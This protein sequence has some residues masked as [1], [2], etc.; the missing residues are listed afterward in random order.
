MSCGPEPLTLFSMK[1]VSVLLAAGKGT[2]MRSETP[3]VLHPLLGA[4]LLEHVLRASRSASS[5][6]AHDVQQ[7]VVVGH[8]AAEV[9]AAFADHE[10][11][12]NI[13]WAV[14]TEQLG[15]GHA[16]RIGVDRARA[17]DD[18]DSATRILILNGDLPL[19]S[20]ETLHG[21]L[22]DFEAVDADVALLTCEADDPTGYGRIQRDSTGRLTGIIEEQDADDQT[23][24][25]KEINVGTYLFRA[26]V[27]LECAGRIDASNAQGEFYLTDV[28]VD[29]AR[30]GQKVVTRGVANLDEIAQVNNRVDLARVGTLLRAQLLEAYMESGVT[31]VDPA[32][33]YIEL[34]VTIGPDT[35]IQPFTHIERGVAIGA[36]CQIGP[37]CH[38][39]PETRI[40][41]GVRLGNFVEI[42]KSQ[43]GQG[44][45][46]PHLTYVGDGVVG[47]GVNIGAGTIFAN[48]DGKRKHVTE[49]KD[50][51]S[52]GSGTVLVA[53]VTVG[54]GARTAAGAVVPANKD[55]PDGEIVAGVPARLLKK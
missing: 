15:T 8:G 24:R 28:V 26:S 3:K 45:K 2:R 1:L 4:P 16:A 38:L 37:F 42:K 51:A 25:M 29:A 54:E 35:V 47:A 32:T 55:V 21:L 5:N 20:A 18:Q 39:R 27:F 23:R 19:L 11:G 17:F 31:I 50:G 53:P 36:R 43:I 44:S 52:L 9:E 34:D 10:L 33:T 6:G 48:Y 49:V 12:R 41:D 13:T 14:Q 22:A 46:V 40:S 30:N 7:V